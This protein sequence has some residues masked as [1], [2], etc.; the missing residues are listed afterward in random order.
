MFTVVSLGDLV[1]DIVFTIE[2]LPLEHERHQHASS[3]SVE[4]GGTGNFLIAG[5]RL[6]MKMLPLGVL[7]TDML[8]DTLYKILQD[9]GIA[10]D[11]IARFAG[12]TTTPVLVLVDQEGQHVFVGGKQS[13]ANVHFSEFWQATLA[14]A[15]ALFL[16]GFTLLEPQL[17]AAVLPILQYARQRS[18][19]VVFDP[20][21]FAAQT[22]FAL[23]QAVLEYVTLLVLTEAEIPLIN[24]GAPDDIDLVEEFRKRGDTLLC[25][26]R[27][28][29][30]CQIYFGERLFA[31]AGFQVAARDTTGAGDT[32]AS[33]LIYGWLHKW[34]LEKVAMFAN[35]M[36][37]A[38]AQKIGSG[39]NAPTRE[40]VWKVLGWEL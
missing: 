28:G 39:R 7:G 6:G 19:P 22:S 21:P 10:T 40:E 24:Q 29:E 3:V 2:Q 33:A 30:G 9:E 38:M 26:K 31:H 36:G 12:S 18:I 13:G 16:C 23:K 15:D 37:A 27:G 14:S 4:P 35:A 32:F 25:I 34:S 5:A 20:G 8:G 17:Q 11:G 1:A